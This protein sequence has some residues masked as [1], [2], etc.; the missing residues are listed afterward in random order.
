MKTVTLM[1]VLLLS[2]WAYAQD[3]AN[4]TVGRFV[5][6]EGQADII[7]GDTHSARVR[8]MRAAIQNASMQASSQVRSSQ[9]VEDGRLSMDYLRINS[10]AQVTAVEVVSEGAV[11]NLYRV[12][13]EARVSESQMCANHV[14]NDFSKSLA[15]TGFALETPTQTT[16]GHLGAV[17]R[18]LP[19]HLV[20]ELNGAGGVRA[21]NAN[22]LMMYPSIPTAPTRVSARNTLTRAVDTARDL[23]VQ[24]VVSGVVRDLGMQE[25]ERPREESDGL[26]AALTQRG[27]VMQRHM[28]LDVY[29]H[30]G[31]S[32]ALVFQSRYSASGQWDFRSNEKVG[33]ATPKFFGS[34][35][36]REVQRLFAQVVE[37]IHA[38]VECQPF[39][40]NIAQVDGQTIFI[41]MGAE[42]GL[43]PG[44]NLGVYRTSTFFDREQQDYTQ[45]TDTK[46]VARV[47]Q[48]QPHFAIAEL[49]VQVERLNLQPDDLVIAW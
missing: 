11:G 9:V 8:A 37:D 14:V 44:D 20:N 2:S 45:L 27:R 3:M 39:M 38:T 21:L 48:V 36:G 35:F 16:I 7:Y 22:Y 24:F 30:D 26:L 41:K 28:V 32:G 25:M 29:I 40:A 31:Y 4:V 47:T 18:S 15:V 1:M 46:L 10:A 43:R 13:I 19:S 34:D 33:F 49:P 6:A 42:S 23:G 12:A 17:D 5:Q